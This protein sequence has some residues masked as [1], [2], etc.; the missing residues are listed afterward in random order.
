MESP[1]VELL[2]RKLQKI[3]E[4]IGHRQLEVGHNRSD[5][6]ICQAAI[7][8]LKVYNVEL[9]ALLIEYQDVLK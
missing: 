7:E 4:V 5:T 8:S 9:S 6:V 2:R 3:C 1:K